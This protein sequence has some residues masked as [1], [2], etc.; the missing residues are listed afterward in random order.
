MA[1]PSEE[2]APMRRG[3]RGNQE[4]SR[5]EYPLS[6]PHKQN[7][8]S[9]NTPGVFPQHYE[10]TTKISHISTPPKKNIFKVAPV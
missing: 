10:V 8:A 9:P 2:V 7:L 1:T 4:E 5:S 3:A 6:D